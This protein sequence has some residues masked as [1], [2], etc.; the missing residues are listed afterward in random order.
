MVEEVISE[1]TS[2]EEPVLVMKYA[3]KVC[4]A[5]AQLMS[6]VAVQVSL[7]NTVAKKRLRLGFKLVSLLKTF[8]LFV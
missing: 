6:H 8:C 5:D 2:A 4:V 3:K 1:E 7:L